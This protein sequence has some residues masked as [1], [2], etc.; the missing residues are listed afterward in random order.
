M[1]ACWVDGEPADS[2]AALDRGLHYGDGL[3]ETLPVHDAVIPLLDL[4]LERLRVGCERLGMPMPAEWILR[5]ELLNATRGQQQAVLKLLVT[6]GSGG[7]GYRP[8]PNPSVTRILLRY[9]WPDYPQRWSDEGVVLRVCA[10]RIGSGAALAGLK[11]LNRLEQVLAR[12]EWTENDQVQEGLMLDGEGAV[13]EGT[14]TNVFSSPAEGLLLTPD[15]SRAG[16]SGVMR[17][18]ILR[19]AEEAGMRI[20]IRPMK[21]HELLDQRE[22]FV[23]NSV[24][25]VWPVIRIGER[26]Y[27]PGP[28][29]RLAQRWAGV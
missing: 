15:L 20:E 26:G 28:M 12:N 7:R 19:Q 16:V 29:T 4:H 11:H 5:D 17:R 22:V 25:G 6:R 18:H 8:L 13:I 9:P 24:I 23:C 21:L 10:T 1:N 3:F 2:V 14:M 27:T